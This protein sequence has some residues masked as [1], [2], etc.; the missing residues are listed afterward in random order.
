[1]TMP[2]SDHIISTSAPHSSAS[3]E[4]NAMPHGVCTWAP[5]GERMQ[6]RQSPISSRNRSTTMVRSSG[7]TPVA[8]T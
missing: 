4:R 6:M 5:N 2:S 7:T 8:S 1:M 3:F